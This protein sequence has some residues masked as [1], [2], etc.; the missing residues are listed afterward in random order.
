[1]D[2]FEPIL[3]REGQVEVTGSKFFGIRKLRHSGHLVF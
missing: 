3:P 1:M 2:P